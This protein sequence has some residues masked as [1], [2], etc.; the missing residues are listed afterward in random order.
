MEKQRYEV[1][2]EDSLTME[3]SIKKIVEG[4]TNTIILYTVKKVQKIHS[5][6][7]LKEI[8]LESMN[9]HTKIHKIHYQH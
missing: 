8:E 9:T 4:N 2:R 6:T 5:F 7:F 1:N 3:Y